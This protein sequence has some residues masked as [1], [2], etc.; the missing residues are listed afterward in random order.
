MLYPTIQEY[1]SNS[2]TNIEACM[3]ECVSW[4]ESSW[5][6]VVKKEQMACGVVV[7]EFSVLGEVR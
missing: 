2:G 4:F 5:R 1:I 6:E 7:K 3:K